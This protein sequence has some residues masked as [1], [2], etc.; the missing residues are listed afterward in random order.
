MKSIGE[1]LSN[2]PSTRGAISKFYNIFQNVN[3]TSSAV[4]KEAGGK[5]LEWDISDETSKKYIKNTHNS[6]INGR[7]NLIQLKKVVQRPRLNVPIGGE[8]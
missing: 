8:I 5:E 6:S 3:S 4:F 2:K 7:S 1:S